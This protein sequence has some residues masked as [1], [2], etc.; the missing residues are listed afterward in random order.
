MEKIL[1]FQSANGYLKSLNLD[2][3]DVRTKEALAFEVST[4]LFF[5]VQEEDVSQLSSVLS[6]ELRERNTDQLL[7]S[8]EYEVFFN[9][10]NQ[11]DE[12][13]ADDAH[14]LSKL[15]EYM[16]EKVSGIVKSITFETFGHGLVIPYKLDEIQVA[17]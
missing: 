4:N 1:E 17:E 15:I 3:G 5:L 12:L 14:Y 7:L 16:F 10:N 11:Y 13:P 8:L 6:L 2:T 9:T